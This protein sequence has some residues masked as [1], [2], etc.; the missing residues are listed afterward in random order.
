MEEDEGGH[1]REMRDES[2]EFQAEMKAEIG[3]AE[4]TQKKKAEMRMETKVELGAAIGGREQFSKR[5]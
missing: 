5:Q 1:E 4:M 3:A 2:T